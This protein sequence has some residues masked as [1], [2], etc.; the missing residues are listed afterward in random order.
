MIVALWEPWDHFTL[1]SGSRWPL[2]AA[3]I[4]Y[5]RSGKAVN[6]HIRVRHDVFSIGSY[7][8]L[9]VDIP[10]S[11]FRVVIHPGE[12]NVIRTKDMFTAYAAG[13]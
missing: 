8:A 1:W 2:P 9:A 10:A 5:H 3:W 11:A 12:L 6:D 7:F 13:K 4:G